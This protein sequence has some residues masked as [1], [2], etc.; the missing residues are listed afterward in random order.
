[1]SIF[2]ECLPPFSSNILFFCLPSKD[3]N[4]K[5]NKTM[6]LLVVSSVPL[7]FREKHRLK[8][9]EK[10]VLRKICVPV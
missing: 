3:L 6:I 2:G 8:A 5:I 4:I 7:M 1:M 10:M 9:Y